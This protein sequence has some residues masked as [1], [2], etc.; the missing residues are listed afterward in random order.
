MVGLGS[1]VL[2]DKFPECQIEVERYRVGTLRLTS[3]LRHQ[4]SISVSPTGF[5]CSNIPALFTRTYHQSYNP[6]RV[7][8]INVIKS[9][10]RYI[11]QILH[12]FLLRNVCHNFH[13]LSLRTNPLNMFPSTIQIR[14]R[15][16]SKNNALR[17]CIRERY[18]YGLQLDKITSI[19]ANLSDSLACSSKD[20]DFSFGD[21]AEGRFGV[22]GRVNIVMQLGREIYR[23]FPNTTTLE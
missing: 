3:Q 7:I 10:K 13:N 1:T 9:I 5:P 16:R 19:S 12:T 4:V 17:P 22:N 15:P 8:Y 14:F 18:R 11:K 2:E 23:H 20:N 6:Q 21:I